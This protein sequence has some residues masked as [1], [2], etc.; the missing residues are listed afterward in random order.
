MNEIS[1]DK[2]LAAGTSGPSLEDFLCEGGRPETCRLRFLL[3]VVPRRGAAADQDDHHESRSGGKAL[4]GHEKPDSDS[5]R[6]DSA[7]GKCLG[8][9]GG[10]G[11]PEDRAEFLPLFTT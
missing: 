2:P 1:L 4:S 7:A 6:V 10:H 11:G 8:C 9:R 5:N 3:G